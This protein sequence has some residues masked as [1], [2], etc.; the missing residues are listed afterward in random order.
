VR[1]FLALAFVLVASASAHAQSASPAVR[2]LGGHVQL[3]GRIESSGETSCSQ[4]Y[5]TSHDT[6]T[7]ALDVTA[8]GAATLTVD[9]LTQ[10]TF[11]DASSRFTG[12]S[13]SLTQTLSRRVLTGQATRTS[14]TLEVRF[15]H[16]EDASMR[17]AGPGVGTLAPGT[18]PMTV[19]LTMRCGVADRPVLPATEVTG[20]QPTTLPLLRCAF[21]APPAFIEYDETNELF[22]GRGTGVRVVSHQGGWDPLRT[23][24][25]R[26]AD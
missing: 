13:P 9:A 22:F 6:I 3:S 17:W 24:A 15:T 2:G 1:R 23:T 14:G 21:D 19:A 16:A 25:I 7:L 26:L 20:E 5:A 10:R 8:R 12:G 11:G 4:S 18:T